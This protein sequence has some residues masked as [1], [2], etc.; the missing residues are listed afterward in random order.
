MDPVW[1]TCFNRMLTSERSSILC[2]NTGHWPGTSSAGYEASLNF[3]TCYQI[4]IWLI[5][6]LFSILQLHIE[7]RFYKMWSLCQPVDGV[8]VTLYVMFTIASTLACR[9]TWFSYREESVLCTGLTF[10]ITPQI[11]TN[12]S[13]YSSP[14]VSRLQRLIEINV[15]KCR[16]FLIYSL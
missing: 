4:N 8:I 16:I 15:N 12:T 9:V 11:I 2:D 6:S 14:Q 13:T 7:Y 5:L 1:F 10:L 3:V